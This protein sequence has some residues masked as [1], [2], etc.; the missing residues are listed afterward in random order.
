MIH[1]PGSKFHLKGNHKHP[2]FIK[3]GIYTL[4]NIKLKN[5]NLSYSFYCSNYD[6]TINLEFSSTQ[7]GDNFI[8]QLIA[9]S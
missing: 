8:N 3:N 9:L 4:K 6:T 5:K 1:V 7:E 2:F